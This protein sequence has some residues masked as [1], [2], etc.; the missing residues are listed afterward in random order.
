[1]AACAEHDGEGREYEG[2]VTY[3]SWALPSG[4]P[5]GFPRPRL[6]AGVTLEQA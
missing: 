3:A 1:M 6:K 5:D 4:T 2:L